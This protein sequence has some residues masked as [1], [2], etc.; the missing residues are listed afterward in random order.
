MSTSG[1]DQLLGAT[2]EEFTAVVELVAMS[3]QVFGRLAIEK[4]RGTRGA[5]DLDAPPR[6]AD[7]ARN[8][9]KLEHDARIFP[10]LQGN[11]ANLWDITVIVDSDGVFTRGN[12]DCTTAISKQDA[13]DK[14]RRLL[15]PNVNSHFAVLGEGDG[16]R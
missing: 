7:R 5:L 14:D 12:L 15:R 10:R 1:N 16:Y 4:Y 8:S 11:L 9:L 2:I 3:H 13:I 6:S